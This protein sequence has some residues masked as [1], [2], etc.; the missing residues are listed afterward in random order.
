MNR[1]DFPGNGV[2]S[3]ISRGISGSGLNGAG[4]LGRSEKTDVSQKY[5]MRSNG[6]GRASK[7]TPSL[8]CHVEQ[9]NP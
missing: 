2:T 4:D 5:S 6:Q 9:D 3:S 1:L 8:G 7:E